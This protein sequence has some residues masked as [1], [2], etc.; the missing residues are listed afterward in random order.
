[1]SWF[2]DLRR[3]WADPRRRLWRRA[4]RA[5][6]D[7]F[8]NKT[9]LLE[10]TSLRPEH[11]VRTQVLDVRESPFEILFGILR[12]PRPH[13]FSRQFHEV[14]ELWRYDVEEGVVERLKGHNLTRA[15]GE[16]G[17]PSSFGA[18]V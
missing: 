6:D 12:H 18:G 5:L 3:W 17:D 11:R 7:L 14:V 10:P 15:R 13:A 2:S 16:D 4:R 9:E 1:M 8:R